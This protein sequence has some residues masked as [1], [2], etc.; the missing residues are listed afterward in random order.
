[1]YVVERPCRKRIEPRQSLYSGGK[2]ELCR[3]AVAHMMRTASNQSQWEIAS[4]GTKTSRKIRGTFSNADQLT[5]RSR[6]HAGN[7]PSALRNGHDEFSVLSSLKFCWTFALQDWLSI[8]FFMTTNITLRFLSSVVAE[9]RSRW[10]TS[11]LIFVFFQATQTCQQ[12]DVASMIHAVGRCRVLRKNPTKSITISCP[13]C[14]F[15]RQFKAFDSR[16]KAMTRH[17]AGMMQVPAPRSL[18]STPTRPRIPPAFASIPAPS[19]SCFDPYSSP[20]I[21][22]KLPLC[23]KRGSCFRRKLSLSRQ[24]SRSFQGSSWFLQFPRPF[25]DL[26]NGFRIQV[27]FKVFKVR[28]HPGDSAPLTCSSSFTNR[29]KGE[30]EREREREKRWLYQTRQVSSKQRL[31]SHLPANSRR[32]VFNDK[33][34]AGPLR[35]SISLVESTSDETNE[36]EQNDQQ[37]TDHAIRPWVCSHPSPPPPPK[38]KHDLQN[39]ETCD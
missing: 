9:R 15:H 20:K 19:P 32:Q 8:I 16:R 31:V 35:G 23:S 12:R 26:E 2:L 11:D 17:E 37:E 30:R 39:S 18:G 13:S 7:A 6:T 5:T 27:L 10:S 25:Q 3:C 1:M 38:K 36:N 4:K 24:N 29:N 28:T 14:H 21:F 34:I 33:A 22:D